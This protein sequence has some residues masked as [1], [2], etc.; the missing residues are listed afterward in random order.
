[1][2]S[3]AML[4]ISSW[5]AEVSPEKKQRAEQREKMRGDMRQAWANMTPEEREA[6]RREHPEVD[7]IWG[8]RSR[9]EGKSD[10]PKP[11]RHSTAPHRSLSPEEHYHLRRQLRDLSQE[12]R[13]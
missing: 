13:R 12:D 2:A 8:L 1:M 5:A 10:E 9:S 7:D 11:A 4:S 6:L 3:L